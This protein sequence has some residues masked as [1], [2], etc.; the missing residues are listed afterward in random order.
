M[1]LTAAPYCYTNPRPAVST[2]VVIFTIRAQHLKLLLVQRA[3]GGPGGKWVLPGGPVRQDEDLDASAR[4]KLREETG[5]DVYLEQLY[6]FGRPGHNPRERVITVA[7]CALI[8]SDKLQ[9]RAATDAEAVG[10]FGMDEL[11]GLTSDHSEI[12]EL[13]HQRLVAKLDYST[14]AFEFM[15]ELFALSDLQ[16]VYEIILRQEIDKRNFRK[17]VLALEQIEETDEER[18]GG[19]HRPARLYRVKHPGKVAI[20]K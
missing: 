4:R 8:P 9:L 18:R 1:T 5:A 2:D 3:D 6:T 10:W 11:P 15:P 12:V 16:E 14:I 7:Y 17:W 20:I 19:T 13:A